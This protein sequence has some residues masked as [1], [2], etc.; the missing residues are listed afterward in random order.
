MWS[1]NLNRETCDRN[2]INVLA[3]QML[4]V[5]CEQCAA[6]RDLEAELESIRG[7]PP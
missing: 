5:F 6:K 3:A 4:F 7:V 1:V 2:V